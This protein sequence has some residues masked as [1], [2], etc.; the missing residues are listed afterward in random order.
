MAQVPEL[1]RIQPPS[2]NARNDRINIRAQDQGDQILSQTKAVGNLAETGVEMYQIYQND[3]INQIADVAEQEYTK[4][5]NEQ[6]ARLKSY[7]GDPT[8]AYA[9]YEKA[10]VQK[11]SDMLSARPNFGEDVMGAVSSRL[12]K[13][14]QKQSL[15]ADMQRGQQQE[16]YD[17]NIFESTVK[18]KRDG[19]AINAGYIQKDDPTSFAPFED[20]ASEIAT[21][22]AKRG[23]KQGTVTVLPEDAQ[24]YTHKYIDDNGKEVKV[25]MGPIAKSRLF[26]DMS[27]GVK[28]SVDVLIAGGRIEEARILQD[29]YKGY[30]TPKQTASLEKQFKTAGRDQEAFGVID[31]IKGLSEEKQIEKINAIKDGELQQKVLQIKDTNSRRLTNLTN[32]MHKANYDR[33]AKE[34]MERMSGPNPFNGMA[35]LEADPTFKRTLDNMTVK[36]VQSIKEM[37]EAPK[38]SNEDSLM[39]VTQMFANDS[40]GVDIYAIEPQDFQYHLRGLSKA[41]RQ[42]YSRMYERMRS[43]TGPEQEKFFKSSG[44]LLR[45]TLIADRLVKQDERTGNLTKRDYKR[46]LDAQRKLENYLMNNPSLRD[47]GQVREF[48]RKEAADMIKNDMWNPTNPVARRGQPEDGRLPSNTQST[49]SQAGRNTDN[50]IDTMSQRDLVAYQRQYKSMSKSTTFPSRSDAAFRAWMKGQLN[51]GN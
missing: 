31:S 20:N 22:I 12:D 18:M 33:T 40:D 25:N 36:Q 2:Q 26:K 8:D 6:L 35:E 4:W 50:I 49:T 34:V 23:I 51:R 13:T 46:Y 47:V 3:K 9:E 19:L 29:K 48:I 43:Q 37:V 7:Q 10:V 24:T 32:R 38:S 39:K 28:S 41:D 27:D 42:H 21:A 15:A 16:I 1:Q 17:N 44:T 14:I 45:Q 30:L 11:K 5:N